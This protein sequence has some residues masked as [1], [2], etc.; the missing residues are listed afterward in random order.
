MWRSAGS[1][2]LSGL[3]AG[4]SAGTELIRPTALTPSVTAYAATD[5]RLT[6]LSST[7]TNTRLTRL[8][9]LSPSKSL[10]AGGA[11]SVRTSRRSPE[12]TGI[13][14]GTRSTLSEQGSQSHGF[15]ATDSCGKRIPC[16][17]LLLPE[18]IIGPSHFFA[19][20]DLRR[21]VR[22]S[23]EQESLLFIQ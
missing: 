7:V 3:L 14:A 1:A 5:A 9:R 16:L 18:I 20:I 10:A 13:H 11:E 2:E 19:D 21:I 17:V 23:S 12:P 6:G 22:R 8:G 4:E 15:F